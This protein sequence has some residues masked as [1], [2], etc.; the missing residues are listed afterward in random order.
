MS[1]PDHL[2]QLLPVRIRVPILAMDTDKIESR[3]EDIELLDKK[4]RP[5]DT[6]SNAEQKMVVDSNLDAWM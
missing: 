3:F 4:F 2:N 5:E 6:E 1:Y